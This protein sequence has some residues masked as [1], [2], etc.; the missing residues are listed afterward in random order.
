MREKGKMLEREKKGKGKKE[1]CKK[2]VCKEEGLC[3]KEN[4]STSNG[5]AC[6]RRRDS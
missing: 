3:P 6:Y 1:A 4:A 5:R 2:E